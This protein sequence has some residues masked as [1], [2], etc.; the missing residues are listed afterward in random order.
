[1]TQE[2]PKENILKDDYITAAVTLPSLLP[3]ASIPALGLSE[4][5]LYEVTL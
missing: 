3:H 1:M 4:E 2:I 5:S